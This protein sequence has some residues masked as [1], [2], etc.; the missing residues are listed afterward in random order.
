MVIKYEA[1]SG[2]D[3]RNGIYSKI[4]SFFKRSWH[5]VMGVFE[6]EEVEVDF[7]VRQGRVRYTYRKAR[8][9]L[10]D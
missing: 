5:W 2:R 4:G 9:R 8:R 7:R 6:P 1:M 10:A 3:K